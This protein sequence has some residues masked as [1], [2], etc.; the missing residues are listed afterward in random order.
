M[1]KRP[2]APP[3]RKARTQAAAYPK[4]STEPPARAAGDRNP[5]ARQS[6]SAPAFITADDLKDG[7]N[8]FVIGEGISVYQRTNGTTALFITVARAGRA[9]QNDDVF[10]WSMNCN[11]PDRSA[12]QEQIGRN[13]LSWPGKKIAL[14]PHQSDRGTWFVNL[15]R[16]E[17]AD[18][19]IPF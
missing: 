5:A 1:A 6:S 7:P 16:P 2:T 10:T 4:R 9:N 11:S 13:L 12:L 15:H 18:D 3:T 17:R 14:V 19:D 8:A